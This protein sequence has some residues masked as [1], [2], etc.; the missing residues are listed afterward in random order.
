MQVRRLGI[1]TA[2]FSEGKLC[3]RFYDEIEEKGCNYG[4][5]ERFAC[6][7]SLHIPSYPAG[8]CARTFSAAHIHT[9]IPVSE[10]LIITA[11]QG[12]GDSETQDGNG[13]GG[14][15]FRHV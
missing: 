14:G 8:S 4:R 5:V 7:K 13:G 2:K 3:T 15:T 1:F 6:V 12:F 11:N 10:L 9:D